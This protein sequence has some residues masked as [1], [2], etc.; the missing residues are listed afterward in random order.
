MAKDRDSNIRDPYQIGVGMS[1][2]YYSVSDS[3]VAWLTRAEAAALEGEFISLHTH[4]ILQTCWLRQIEGGANL[5]QSRALVDGFI[6][7]YPQRKFGG[8]GGV[9]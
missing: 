2:G 1:D 6:Q 5:E 8:P 4:G 3:F 7:R 9:G